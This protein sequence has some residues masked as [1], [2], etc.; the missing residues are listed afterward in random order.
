MDGTKDYHNK[1]IKSDKDK[2]HTASLIG[3]ILKKDTNEL[4]Y[5]TET[6]SQISKT[7]LWLPKETGWGMWEEI[8]QEFGISMCTLLDMEWMVS[9]D[10]L[11]S[12]GYST[13]YS[14]ITYVGKNLEKN[15]YVYMYNR[16]ILLYSRN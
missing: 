5:K 14:V 7:N 13:Q 8:D 12:T 15:G 10:L 1:W 3:G 2:H 11:Y 4:I 6:N 9:G 16:N